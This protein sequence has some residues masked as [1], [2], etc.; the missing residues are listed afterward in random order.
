M[1]TVIVNGSKKTC[2]LSR[3]VTLRR[4]RNHFASTAKN[5]LSEKGKHV[6]ANGS[7]R[8]SF[9]CCASFRKSRKYFRILMYNEKKIFLVKDLNICVGRNRYTILYVNMHFFALFLHFLFVNDSL[10]HIL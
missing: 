9:Q 6:F 3:W 4:H 8:H 10:Y 1:N 2:S 7:L 5:I